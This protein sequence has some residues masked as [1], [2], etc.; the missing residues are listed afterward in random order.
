MA[1]RES[2]VVLHSGHGDRRDELSD[3]LIGTNNR[4]LI[5]GRD[6]ASMGSAIEVVGHD[7]MAYLARIRQRVADCE[8]FVRAKLD[9]ERLLE[10]ALQ[11]LRHG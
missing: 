3:C 4:I 5:A 2:I 9:Y 10:E 8:R 11:E 6:I 7:Q 1:K